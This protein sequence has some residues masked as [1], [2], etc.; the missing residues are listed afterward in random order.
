MA[1]EPPRSELQ[2][3]RGGNWVPEQGQ[4]ILTDAQWS[5]LGQALRLSERELQILQCIFQDQTE[6]AIARALRISAHTVHTHLER[7]YHK[8]DV[9]SR[10]GLL[11][12]VFAEHLALSTA[13][14]MGR[15]QS[16]QRGEV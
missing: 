13:D 6:A 7:V 9:R 15:L 4:E 2:P 12:R 5:R 10:A 16:P 1:A 14:E 11:V 8:L 3:G